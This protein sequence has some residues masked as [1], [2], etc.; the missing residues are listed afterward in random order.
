MITAKDAV[1]CGLLLFPP[2]G[3]RFPG[4]KS[5]SKD[6]VINTRGAGTGLEL[7]TLVVAELERCAAGGP[8]FD[9]IGGVA[10]A[11][12]SWGAWLAWVMD[13]PF[14]NVLLD[15]PR[16]SGL[17]REVEGDIAGRR[18]LVVDNWTRS[19]DSLRAAATVIERAGGVCVGALTIVRHPAADPGLL[20]CSPWTIQELLSAAL[21]LGLWV[22]P[23][24]HPDLQ[25]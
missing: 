21:D 5:K 10:K 16:A 20:L 4:R 11:G 25:P 22:A 3:Q 6:Y 23:P 15:G 24:S 13:K 17:Q 8:A 1:A 12:T 7:R 14:A 19:G 2:P 18:V 9:T